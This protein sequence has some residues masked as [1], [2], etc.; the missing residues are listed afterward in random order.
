[1]C[2][3]QGMWLISIDN[4]LRKKQ[5]KISKMVRTTIYYLKVENVHLVILKMGGVLF[6]TILEVEKKTCSFF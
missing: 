6:S 5:V 1:M 4:K 2:N 3:E